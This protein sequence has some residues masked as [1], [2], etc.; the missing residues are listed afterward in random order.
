MLS[1]LIAV[2][3]FEHPHIGMGGRATVSW[4]EGSLPELSRQLLLWTPLPPPK[5]VIMNDGKLLEVLQ[6]LTTCSRAQARELVMRNQ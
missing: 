4:S 5:P 3:F 1:R 6:A 2:C